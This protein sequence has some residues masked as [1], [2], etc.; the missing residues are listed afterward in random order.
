MEGARR[1]DKTKLKLLTEHPITNLSKNIVLATMPL[2]K[3]LNPKPQLVHNNSN[4]NNK[5]NKV[6]PKTAASSTHI[7]AFCLYISC[8]Q[9]HKHRHVL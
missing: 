9:K 8:K 7:S 2:T 3:T 1:G 4:G 5:N 6:Q